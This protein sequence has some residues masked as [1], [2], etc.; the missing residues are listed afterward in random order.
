M[1]NLTEF[2]AG[3]IKI[4]YEIIEPKFSEHRKWIVAPLILI[5]MSGIAI[6]LM[7]FYLILG[8][9]FII[10]IFSLLYKIFEIVFPYDTTNHII[11]FDENQLNIINDNKI[12]KQ[13]AYTDIISIKIKVLIEDPFSKSF[14]NNVAYT[15]LIKIRNGLQ[16]KYNVLNDLYET[17]EDRLLY[18]KIPPTLISVLVY[19]KDK[20]HFKIY[21]WKGRK[22]IIL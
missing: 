21:D 1:K 11:E 18:K 17:K 3:L 10:L 4:K 22:H 2:S 16:L 5:V 7:K 8:I 20:Y 14:I 15:L 19:L 6:Y 12:V 13:I 9:L